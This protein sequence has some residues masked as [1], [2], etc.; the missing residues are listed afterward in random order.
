M[1]GIKTIPFHTLPE[2]GFSPSV[3]RCSTLI[4]PKTK[5]IAL[6]TPNNPV[7]SPTPSHEPSLTPLHLQTGATYSQSL[8]ASFAKLARERNVALI[9]DE[10]YRDFITTGPP[11]HLFSPSPNPS[12]SWRTHFIHL[13]SFSK[14]YC[15][16]GLRLGAIVASPVLLTQIKTVLDCLQICPPRPAQL[17]L[18]PLLPELRPFIRDTALALEQRHT[19]FRKLLPPRWRVGAQ[20]GYFAF[21]KHPFTG[22]RAMDVCVRL[23]KE[24]GVITLPA[25]F[26]CE[27]QEDGRTTEDEGGWIRFSVANVD[28]EDVKKVCERLRE[29][30]SL[31]GWQLDLINQ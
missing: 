17:A 31:F 7:R 9:I 27:D 30:E 5:A 26:F 1:L 14:S 11:H 19:L 25:A 4:T 22:V 8:L 6:V 10:T 24:V 3:E 2:D 15:I 20:G 13:F 21:V 28:D 23:A 16:P 12:E 18:A 29:C